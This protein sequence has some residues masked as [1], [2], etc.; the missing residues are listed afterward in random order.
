LDNIVTVR[1]LVRWYVIQHNE[2]LSHAAFNGQT[3]DE[4]Y[5]GRG[6]NVPDELSRRRD[7]ARQSRREKNRQTVCSRC[8]PTGREELAA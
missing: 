5:F 8:P 3:P 4:M 2:V 1:K 6:D 7:E